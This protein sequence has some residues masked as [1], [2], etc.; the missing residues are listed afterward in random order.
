MKKIQVFKGVHIEQKPLFLRYLERSNFGACL[1]FWDKFFCFRSKT[2]SEENVKFDA[3][4]PI[5]IWVR[6][7]VNVIDI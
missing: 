7:C 2:S 6:V 5:C 3:E 1:F 4:L